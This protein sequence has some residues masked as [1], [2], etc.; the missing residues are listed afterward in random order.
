MGDGGDDDTRRFERVENAVRIAWNE[1]P[2]VTAMENRRNFGKPS[3]MSKRGIQVAHKQLAS[4]LLIVLVVLV[5]LLDVD[6]C[7]KKKNQVLHAAD[8]RIRCLMASQVVT[9]VGSLRYSSMR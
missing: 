8:P 5:G 1:Q 6:V 4:A 9:R 2:M 3:Q 7:G